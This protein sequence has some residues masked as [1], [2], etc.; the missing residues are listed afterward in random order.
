MTNPTLVTGTRT[1]PRRI[2]AILVNESIMKDFFAQGL[3]CIK[4]LDDGYALSDDAEL[5][6]IARIPGTHNFEFVFE[7][8]SGVEIAE[9][10]SFPYR[11]PT[12]K[13]VQLEDV[14]GVTVDVDNS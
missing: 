6:D 7:A 8:S 11:N 4:V 10:A 12:I 3:K 9:G 13:T 1:T 5:I 14:T 2:H